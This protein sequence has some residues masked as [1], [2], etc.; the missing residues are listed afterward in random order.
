MFLALFRPHAPGVAYFAIFSPIFDLSCREWRH[1][2]WSP[3]PIVLQQAR[4]SDFAGV[5]Y[6]LFKCT[7]LGCKSSKNGPFSTP[8]AGSALYPFYNKQTSSSLTHAHPRSELAPKQQTNNNISLERIS[9][10]HFHYNKQTTISLSQAPQNH[11]FSR[12]K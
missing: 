3:N 11:L 1:D 4:A 10:S 6:S 2:P 9:N 8:R 12:Q 7:N 5:L